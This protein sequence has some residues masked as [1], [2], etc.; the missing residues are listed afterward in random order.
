MVWAEGIMAKQ[1]KVMGELVYGIHPIIELLKAKNRKLITIYTTRPE[2]KAWKQIEKILPKYPVRVQIVTR[3]AL[4]NIAKTTDHQGVVAFAQPFPFRKKMFDP[5]KQKAVV[6][7][8]GIQDV[9]NLGAI[10]RTVY[11]AGFNGVIIPKKESAPITAATLKAS[12][13][14]AEHVPVYIAASP[15]AAVHELKKAGYEIYLTVFGGKDATNVEYK[16]PLCVVIGNEAVGVSKEIL[17]SGVPITLPQKTSD[18][19]YNASVAA[20]ITLF[21]I[22]NQ[23]KIL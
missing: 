18:I 7:L 19:S 11:C 6:M 15:Q 14:L 23:Q 21:W 17:K 10:L 3:E 12:A 22:A 5:A 4:C 13:G 9:H 1:Q 16:L 8:D 2:P 20:G